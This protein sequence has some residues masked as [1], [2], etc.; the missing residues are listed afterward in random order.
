[1]KKGIPKSGFVITD[2]C[3]L[4]G[5]H[6]SRKLDLLSGNLVSQEEKELHCLR[7]FRNR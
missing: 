7:S 1:M 6:I 3:I 4:A 2:Q 5:H